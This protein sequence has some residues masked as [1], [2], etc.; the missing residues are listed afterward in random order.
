MLKF[1]FNCTE[2]FL[3]CVLCFMAFCDSK[4]YNLMS[5]KYFNRKSSICS[6]CVQCEQ[7]HWNDDFHIHDHDRKT[8]VQLINA[9]NEWIEFMKRK[10]SWM[11]LTES[12]NTLKLL[13][14]FPTWPW[15]NKASCCRLRLSWQICHWEGF[16]WI[17][18]KKETKVCQKL[19]LTPW[20][21]PLRLQLSHII[22]DRDCELLAHSHCLRSLSVT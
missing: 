18:S 19:G 17:S 15:K 21:Q 20:F 8:F 6:M 1:S 12:E 2:K 13:R 5:V 3:I 14:A 9:P 11:R 4:R 22:T 7:D 10:M 16:C